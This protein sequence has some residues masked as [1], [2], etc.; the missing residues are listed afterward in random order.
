MYAGGVAGGIWKSTDGGA[1]WNVADDLLIN[2]AVT[3]IALDPN[4][5]SVLYAGT[6][7]GVLT[8]SPGVRGLGIFKSVDAGA[9]WTQ[10][11]STVNVVPPSAF[12]Y[13]NEVVISP[14]DSNRIYA[15]T[16]TG[17]WRSLDAGASWSVVLSN[18]WYIAAPPTTNGCTV[19][20]TDLAIRADMN[21]DV[22]FAAFGSFGPDGLFRSDD[23]GDTWLAYTTGADQG[24]MTVA[25]APS[26]NDIVYLLMANNGTTGQTGQLMDVFRSD[27]GGETFVG[28]VNM[29]SLTG[30][31]LLSNLILA[32]GCREGGT[33]SQGW[34]DNI[35]AVD[36][37][38]PDIVWVGGV[39]IFRSDD[40]G[41]NWGIPGY[42]IFYTLD[43][44]PP[45][46]IHPDHHNIVFHPQYNGTTNQT[47]Y[48]TN[49]G[50]LFRTTNA[51]AATSQEDCPLPGDEPLPEIVWEDLNH[52]Y[53]VTQFYHGDSAR[54]DDVFIGGCQ[55][56]GSNRVQAV[57]TPNDWDLIF[58]GD[59]GY[60]AIDPTASNVMYVE[61]Q[62]F[63]TIQKSVD[64]GETFLNASTTITDTDGLFITPIAMDQANPDVLWTGG[65]RPWRTINAALTW[66]PL[67]P[68]FAGPAKI[69]AIGIAPSDS[70]VV[71]LGFNNGYVVRTTHGLSANPGW[72]IFVNGL[73]GAW[74][75]SVAVDPQDPD[76]AYITYS[77]F[78][79]PHVM[80]TTNGG[81]NWSS[82]DGIDFE[83][84]PDIP[85]H[86]VAVRPCNSQQLYVGTELGVFASDDGGAS[87]APFNT[88]LAHTVVE[89]LDWKNEN[90]LVAFTHGRGAFMTELT[91]CGCPW[92]LDGSGSVGVTDFLALLAVW[93]TDPGGPPD[94]DG[95]GDVGVTDFLLLLASWG[96]C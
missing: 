47:M 8:G 93:G 26:D 32:T 68:N 27:D 7:E 33:Y 37:V 14:N 42:W 79:V 87:W 10:L 12:H 39:D 49:D 45:Y 64:G 24:R 25:L 4:D 40:G 84:V 69:S 67:G 53:G 88:G 19:G 85:A 61:Y 13:V 43:P 5:T 74:V 92:D 83:G 96:P 52:N 50:G 30:P 17:V 91:P 59:G 94:F 15:A 86:W 22:I 35:I 51:R 6:G 55:D 3:S 58:G 72:E 36:P 9:T 28:R 77:S 70:N 62:G 60:T 76:T 57:G 63:P 89:T 31:W 41:V 54:L 29:D 66:Q 73:V 95:D 56:N 2:L 71:Y 38:D 75:S 18:P 11:E 20:C 78:G 80:R 90:T 1:S 34:Y 81:Q 48:V 16:R 46:Y 82:I 65:T 21:P 44:P 23:G